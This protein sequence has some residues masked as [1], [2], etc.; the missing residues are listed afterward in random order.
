LT[1]CINIIKKY[2]PV[3]VVEIH[4]TNPE[5]NK[6]LDFLKKY[7]YKT[8]GINYASSPTFVYTSIN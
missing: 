1:G 5:Y 4:K 3:I 6:I 2:K 8:D 7:N